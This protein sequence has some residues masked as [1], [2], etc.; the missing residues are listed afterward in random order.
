[1]GAN[2]AK[3]RQHIVLKCTAN[4]IKTNFKLLVLI[5]YLTKIGNLWVSPNPIYHELSGQ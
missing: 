1:M 2:C 5:F 3:I 4:T